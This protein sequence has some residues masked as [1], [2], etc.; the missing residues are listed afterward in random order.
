MTP[1]LLLKAGAAAICVGLAVGVV[2]SVAAAHFSDTITLGSVL[3]G[4]AVMVVAGFGAVRSQIAR[5][6]RD[7]WESEKTLRVEKEEALARCHEQMSVEREEQRI[8]RHQLK[9][10]LATAKAQ[11][12]VL[13]TRTDFTAYEQRAV[14]RNEAVLD[15]LRAVTESLNLIAAR[16]TKGEA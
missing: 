3:V 16:L 7:S 12:A 13:E 9:D 1:A 2:D 10:D 5:N 11:V 6:Y 14:A 15:G 8:I 4:L